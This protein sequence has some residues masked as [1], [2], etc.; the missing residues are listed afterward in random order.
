MRRRRRAKIELATGRGDQS[1]T[2]LGFSVGAIAPSAFATREAEVNTAASNH[3]AL[4]EACRA[5][6]EAQAAVEK[7]YARWSELETKRSPT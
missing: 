5:L 1:P 6:E 7:L 3:T 4:A 2:E